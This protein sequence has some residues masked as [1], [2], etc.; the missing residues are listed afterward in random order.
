MNSLTLFINIE[1][2]LNG[3]TFETSNLI[4]KI[5]GV[6]GKVTYIK[7]RRIEQNSRDWLETEIAEKTTI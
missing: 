2:F 5:A 1:T 4:Q 7:E 3:E 6:S